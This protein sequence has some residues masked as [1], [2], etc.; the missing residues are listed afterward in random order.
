MGSGNRPWIIGAA[1]LAVVAIVLGW[2]VGISPQ[3]S[4]ASINDSAR[5]G[6]ESQNSTTQIEIARLKKQ[7]DNLPALQ[8][9]LDTLG[10][11]VPNENK[12]EEF[13]AQIAAATVASGAVIKTITFGDAASFVPTLSFLSRMPPTVNPT[14]F[15]TIPYTMSA[16]G[17]KE[18]LNAFLKIVQLGTRMTI[19]SSVVSA[20]GPDAA[21]WGSDITGMTFVLLD[22]PIA[23]N[24]DG[25]ATTG[26]TSP[27]AT[28]TPIPAP[29]AGG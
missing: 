20:Q 24:P 7:F 23:V 18:Q 5:A 3:L 27:T 6:I 13:T 26:G 2:F 11:T 19:M 15:V 21:V 14:T 9:Q 12:L 8:K 17:T 22:V 28:P 10:V 4:I 25:A 16:T 29:P 1:L